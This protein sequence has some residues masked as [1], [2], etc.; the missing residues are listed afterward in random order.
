[1]RAWS[2]GMTPAFQ[3]GSPGS[4]PGARTSTKMSAHQCAIFV[5]AGAEEAKGFASVESNTARRRPEA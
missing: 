5:R 3:A 4:I 2:N 1:M